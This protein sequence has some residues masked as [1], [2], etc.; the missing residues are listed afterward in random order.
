M[1]LPSTFAFDNLSNDLRALKDYSYV[2]TS[3]TLKSVDDN[4]VVAN[5]SHFNSACAIIRFN[6]TNSTT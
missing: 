2:Y 4:A 1:S 5:V 6:I 3:T